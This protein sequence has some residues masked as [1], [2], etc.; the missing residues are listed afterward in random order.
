MLYYLKFSYRLVINDL[1]HYPDF[2]FNFSPLLVFS[3][4]KTVWVSNQL[5]KF[6]IY[7]MVS[8]ELLDII[9]LFTLYH[10]N[11]YMK[12]IVQMFWYFE[13]KQQYNIFGNNWFY[14]VGTVDFHSPHWTLW[15]TKQPVK[16]WTT[17]ILKNECNHFS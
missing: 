16:K 14:L 10:D 15:G 2:V 3:I 1:I 11:I 12:C 13:S 6:L 4:V 8:Y 5:C 7:E 9:L 17:Y